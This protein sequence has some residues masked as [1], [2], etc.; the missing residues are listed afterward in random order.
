M[1]TPPHHVD[2]VKDTLPANDGANGNRR[3]TTLQVNNDRL[4]HPHA[5]LHSVLFFANDA[6]PDLHR[7]IFCYI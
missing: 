1:A 5:I 7:L 6:S 2:G 3:L 4:V